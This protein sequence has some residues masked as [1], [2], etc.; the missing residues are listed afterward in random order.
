MNIYFCASTV[1][2]FEGLPQGC[3]TWGL[4]AF[5]NAKDNPI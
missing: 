5:M 2:T 4:K 3:F 1:N